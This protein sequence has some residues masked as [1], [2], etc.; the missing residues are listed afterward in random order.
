M[1][2]AEVGHGLQNVRD[3][4][5]HAPAAWGFI[6]IPPYFQCPVFDFLSV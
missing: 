5:G 6:T 1:Y 2:S 3:F 4:K